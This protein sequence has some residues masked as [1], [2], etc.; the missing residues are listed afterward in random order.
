MSK[1][2][3]AAEPLR[4][5]QVSETARTLLDTEGE[6]GRFE[7]KQ[8]PRSVKPEVLCAAANWVALQR[9][10]VADVTLLVGVT[11]VKDAN[12]GLVKGEIV[13][14]KNLQTAVETIQNS[15][16]E[17]RPEPVSVTIIEEGVATSKPFLR[18]KIRPTFTPHY[19]AEGRRQT[20]NNAS[21]RPLS[22][23]EL[24]DLYLDRE[25]AKFE[26]RF[27]QT[28]DRVMSH[29][30]DIDFA[31]DRVAGDLGDID[32]SIDR[33]S[34]DFRDLHRAAWTAAEEAEESKSLAEQLESDITELKRDV[35]GQGG[36]TPAGLFFR[37]MDKRWMVWDAFSMDAAYRPTKMTDQLVP[38]LKRLLEEPIPPDDWLTNL[39]EIDFWDGVLRRRNNKWTMTAWSRAIKQRENLS[40]GSGQLVME[41][42]ISEFR[43]ERERI[44]AAKP[45]KKSSKPKN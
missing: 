34:D 41:D 45:L 33:L 29:L 38:R 36:D 44:L 22:D 20:R 6:S 14:V 5:Q 7:F 32:S 15:I 10:G 3:P 13:G 16:R 37:L 1:S 8:T 11:E 4:Y 19:D 35:L 23:E 26:Q 43:A 30:G 27:Q 42:R 18:I 28:A 31:I 12:T 39:T 2:R 25:A 21:T 40:S 17:T 9:G 24:L